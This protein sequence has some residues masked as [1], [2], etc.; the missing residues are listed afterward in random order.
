[1]L[2]CFEGYL[3]DACANCDCWK[4]GSDGSLGCAYPGPIDNCEAFA[5]AYKKAEE[6]RRK[7]EL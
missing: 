5:E 4:D 1:M 3:T 2:N 6:L 7:G